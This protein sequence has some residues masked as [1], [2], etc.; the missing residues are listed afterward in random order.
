MQPLGVQLD[1]SARAAA[2]TKTKIAP[3][4]IQGLEVLALPVSLLP[5]YVTAA[6]ESNPLLEINYDDDLFRF[7][8]LPSE[9]VFS[10][11]LRRRE[12]S[13]ASA[14]EW[15]FSRMSDGL[16]EQETLHSH[17]HLQAFCMCSSEEDMR[18]CAEIIDNISDDGYFTGDLG[19][20]AFEC[21]TTSEHAGEM[22]S[23]VQRMQ[24]AGVGARDL[25]ECLLLQIREDDPYRDILR[26]MIGGDL[27]DIA[28]NRLSQL[29]RT[30]RL[31]P[32]ELRCVHEA[33]LALNPRPGSEFASQGY[34]TYVTPDLIIRREGFDFTV[35][36]VGDS[37][38][39]LSLNAQ[40]LAMADGGSLMR[41]ARDYLVAKR[42]EATALLRNLDQRKQT[43]YRFGLFLIERQ[44]RFFSSGDGRM[45]PLTM[46]QAADSLG[47]HVS[48]VS[49]T[50]Q[51]KFVQTPRG[52]YPMKIFFSRAVP[53]K[54]ADSPS[55]QLSAFDIKN[56]IRGFVDAED[57]EHPLSDAGITQ[58]LND[59]GIDIKRRTVAKY[60]ESLG[61]D[62]Q[63]RRRR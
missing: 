34:A 45:A 60:R 8:Q 49:R 62:T 12:T 19:L 10:H 46:Q 53:S 57:P 63:S 39:C 11:P 29:A 7:E 52:T 20:V 55:G 54:T 24:P 15:D 16:S 36:V 51:G 33:V 50:V 56:L 22:L 18:V 2:R 13:H 28:A 5:D 14:I 6:A 3:A 42:E 23:L 30:Y 17:L 41:E 38:S 37:Q 35:E 32:R 59:R 40:Y 9:E 43:L 4:S 47:V 61:I 48:T 44:H 31:S 21:G 26:E 27:E 25:R 1:S 58:M